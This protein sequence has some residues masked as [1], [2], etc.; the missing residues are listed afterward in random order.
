MTNKLLFT[1]LLSVILF[2]TM[3]LTSDAYADSVTKSPT[4][5][6]TDDGVNDFST[7]DNAFDTSD[8]TYAFGD[9]GDSQAYSGFGFTIP[10]DATIDGFE[11]HLEG[12]EGVC[13]SGDDNP[14]FQF[15]LSDPGQTAFDNG[16][17]SMMEIQEQ[18]QNI[19]EPQYINC[20]KSY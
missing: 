10:L 8:D 13:T 2:A 16:N 12:N 1:V 19:L 6:E 4:F 11:V 9:Q 15:E 14:R 3:S 5:S 7:V 18:R 17:D 20:R